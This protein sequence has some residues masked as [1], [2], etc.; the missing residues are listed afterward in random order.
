MG[1]GKNGQNINIYTLY[2]YSLWTRLS[3]SGSISYLIEYD[4]YSEFCVFVITR[5][6]QNTLK[7]ICIKS[8][9][10]SDSFRE[11]RNLLNAKTD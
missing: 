1:K 9:M 6:D 11:N 8:K 3:K 7:Q 10:H 4:T 5:A 2:F